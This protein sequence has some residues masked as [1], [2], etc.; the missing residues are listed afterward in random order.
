LYFKRLDIQGFKSFADPVSIEFH[1]GITC[2]VGPNGSGKSNISDAI[3]WVLGEQSPKM[4]RGGKMEE[5][6]FAGTANRKSRGMAEVTLVIDNTSGALPIDYS[7]VAITRRMYRSGESEYSINNNACRLRDIRELIMDTG[8]GVDGYSLIGQGKIAEIVSNKPESRREIFEEAAGIVKYRSKKAEAERKLEASRGNL[9]R[10]NDIIGEIEGRIE[11]LAEDSEKASEYLI[12]KEKYK[13]L[14]INITLKNIEAVELKNEYIKDELQELGG[15]IDNFK[16]TKT[17]LDRDIAENRARNEELENA[18]I[19]MRDRLMA[20]TEAIS[21]LES[22]G[23][24]TKEKLASIEKDRERLE[25]EIETVTE[26]L[27]KEEANAAEFARTRGEVDGEAAELAAELAEK[28]SRLLTLTGET[29]ALERELEQKKNRLFDLTGVIGAK[30]T[31]KGSLEALRGTLSRRKEQL[32]SENRTSEEGSV[33]LSR[34]Q[35]ET[36]AERDRIRSELY[37]VARSVSAQKN[38]YNENVTRERQLSQRLSEL[39][40][41]AGQIS[42]RKKLLEE[43][44]SSY[45][46]YNNAVKYIMRNRSLQGVCGVVAELITVP[47]GFETAVETALGF[48]VQNI[49]VKDDRSAKEAVAALKK[50]RAGRLT[51]LPVETMNRKNA[52]NRDKDRRGLSGEPGFQGYGVDCVTFDD[53]YRGVMEYLLGR[54]VVVDGLDNAVKMSKLSAAGGLRF[55]T[56][57]GEVINASG[58]I[59]G[60]TLKSSTSNL[61]ERKTEAASLGEK[62]LGIEDEQRRGAQEL[63]ELQRRIE[64]GRAAIEEQEKL[65]RDAEMRLMVKE[66][67]LRQLT[68]QLSDMEDS[69]AKWNREL[70]SI[71][72]EEA[73]SSKMIEELEDAMRAAQAEIS[74]IEAQ[75]GQETDRHAGLREQSAAASEEVTKARLAVAAAESRRENALQMAERV[76]RYIAELSSE[77]EAK[78]LAV[79]ELASEKEG[80]LSGETDLSQVRKERE[81]EKRELEEQLARTQEEKALIVRYLSEVEQKKEKMDETLFGYQSRKHELELK[82][83]RNEAQVD[84]YKEKL[85]DE[86]EISYI[87]A[88]EFEKKEFLLAQA[89]KESREIKS[90]MRELGDVNVGAIREYETVKERYDFL[91]EQ[92]ADL[93]SAMDSLKQII[94]DMDRTIRLNFKESFDKIVD[95]FE[96]SFQELFGGGMAELRLED[97][98]RPLECGIEIV[99]QPPGKKLQNINLMSGG[100]KTMTAIALMFAVLKA[101]PT[102]FCILDEV[103]AALDEANIDRFAKYLKNFK[104]IQFALVTHQKV[105]MEYADVMYGVTM[106]EQ[107]ISKVLSLRLGDEIQL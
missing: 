51:F 57:E 64:A 50:N 59:T 11:G 47:R 40:V 29:E 53:Q 85:W 32:L 14:E 102:P 1:E 66:N 3:R 21:R 106:P 83:A 16:E 34:L 75:I 97:E 54:V 10:V 7:E 81:A 31:E 28:N 9:D 12:L 96:K 18:G 38:E 56:L 73:S 22:R 93:L 76:Q 104:E 63:A 44:E 92:R 39:R 107:G 95:N 90:R 49:V 100:E 23:Q 68:G 105:T 78:K 94:D 4:L 88:M 55:V 61:L 30:R 79:E 17:A 41:S 2:I 13:N 8:I 6:I 20:E 69:R 82:K 98:S 43:L 36:K 37:A 15:Q 27:R 45:E 71:E 103:E 72:A 26:K 42:A 99:A 58:A 86:F 5:V 65:H 74:Q 48:A 77:R 67:E 60:G 24:V 46:G 84:T 62:L 25:S 33:N 101:K 89:T 52:G 87:Q 35:E 80:L 91:T 70:S 19:D